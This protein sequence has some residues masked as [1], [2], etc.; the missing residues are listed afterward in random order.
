SPW[1]R[2]RRTQDH[3]LLVLMRYAQRQLR[4]LFVLRGCFRF[5]FVF[6]DRRT[7]ALEQPRWQ[8]LLRIR[9]EFPESL[10]LQQDAAAPA[11]RQ[12]AQQSVVFGLCL[13]QLDANLL[14]AF[15]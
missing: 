3:S 2:D 15:D 1:P 12:P 14:D 10:N 8:L 5:A 13:V 4:R 7:G 6:I 9:T 11:L